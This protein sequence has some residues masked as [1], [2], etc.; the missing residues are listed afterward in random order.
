MNGAFYVGAVGLDAQQRALDTLSNNIANINTPSFKRSDVRFSAVLA[1]RSSPDTPA[2]DLDTQFS[3]A[4]VQAKSVPSIDE[5]GQIDRS[6][7]PMDIA[8]DGHGF[9][10]LLGPNGQTYL[11]RGGHLKLGKDGILES[12][13]GGFPLKAMV[14]VP[15]DASSIS[16]A[17]DGTVSATTEDHPQ[18]T[19]IG[20]IEVVKSE[21]I[22]GLV[23]LDGGFFRV[24]DAGSLRTMEPGLPGTGTLVQGALE[25]GNVDLTTEMVSLLLVQRAYAANAQVIQAADQMAGIANGLKR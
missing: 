14:S 13:S 21:D 3:V 4:G 7:S 9:I 22:D 25:R 18:G 24:D 5:P 1:V 6:G 17:A 8:I 10:E 15:A 12:A 2:P 11:W 23:A 20:R 19:E 16:I